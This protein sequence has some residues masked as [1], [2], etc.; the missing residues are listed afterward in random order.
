MLRPRMR[1]LIA[2][3][4]LLATLATTLLAGPAIHS[5]LAASNRPQAYLALGDSVAFGFNP[6]L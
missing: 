2:A 3:V 1:W 4:V 6:T 5:T